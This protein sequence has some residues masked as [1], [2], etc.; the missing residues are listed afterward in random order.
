MVRDTHSFKEL[1]QFCILV[2]EDLWF[3]ILFAVNLFIELAR[4]D[5]ISTMDSH[6]IFHG[7]ST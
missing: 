1:L 3:G 5:V 6:C 2:F 4:C 7:S